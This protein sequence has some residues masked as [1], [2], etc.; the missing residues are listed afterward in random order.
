MSHIKEIIPLDTLKILMVSFLKQKRALGYKYVYMEKSLNRFVRYVMSQGLETISLTQELV[1]AYCSRHSGETSK[2]QAN[3]I[4]DIRQFA[5]FLNT[6]GFKAFIPNMPMKTRSEFTPYIFT[7]TEIEKIFNTVDAI[8]PH[9]RYNCAEVYPV[10]F[11]VLYGCGLRISEALNLR[12][13]D[14][15]LE[16]SILTIRGGKNNKS[17]LV[18][19]S[20][21]VRDACNYLMRKIH[22]GADGCNYFFK[23]RDGSK[24]NESTVYCIFREILWA[25]GIPHRGKG[26]GPRLHDLRHCFCCHALKQMSN[27]GIDMYCAL[28]VLSAYV[29][30]SKITS[31]E[32]YLRLTEEFYPDVSDKVR[33]AIPQVY[34]EVYMVEAN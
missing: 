25:S 28:P 23:N 19:I 30:H 27:A 20:Q 11:R 21:S 14:V 13:C 32:Q 34:P 9:T 33:L 26:F 18:A 10:L 8:K 12:I 1:M 5:M 3:R 7:H 16:N 17:R 4:S 2:S 22:F 24:R 29:G 6:N 31:T 15:D